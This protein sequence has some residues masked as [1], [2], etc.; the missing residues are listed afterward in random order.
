M[1]LYWAFGLKEKTFNPKNKNDVN[2]IENKYISVV[3]Y[4][5]DIN[6]SP[7]ISKYKCDLCKKIFRDGSGLRKHKKKKKKCVQGTSPLETTESLV[8]Y[9]ISEF[10]KTQQTLLMLVDA[11]KT[12]HNDTNN[13]K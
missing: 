2:L 6:D 1:L 7:D 4:I 11:I 8:K 12:I 13:R 10:R 5:D 3:E 9:L